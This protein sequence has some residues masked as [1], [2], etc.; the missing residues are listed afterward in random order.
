MKKKKKGSSLFYKTIAIILPIML[1]TNLIVLSSAYYFTYRHNYNHCAEDVTK[2]AKV[3]EDFVGMY[4]LTKEDDVKQCNESISA[5]CREFEITYAYVL[6]IDPKTKNETYITLGAGKDA[7]ETYLKERYPGYTVEGCVNQEQI[8]VVSGKKDYAVLR[9]IS[10]IDDTVTC[11]V[12]LKHVYDPSLNTFVETEKSTGCIVGAEVSFQEII[13]DSRNNFL[14]ILLAS[15]VLSTLM[16]IVFATVAKKKIADPATAISRYMKNFVAGEAG[17]LEKIQDIKGV[18]EYTDMAESFNT[19]VDEINHY[20][21]D[22]ENLNKEKHIAE[23]EMNITRSIQLGLLPPAEFNNKDVNI[24]A[25]TLPAREVGGDLYAY[26]VIPNGIFFAVADVSGKG[27]SAALFVS[28]AL[29]LLHMYAALGYTPT[30]AMAAYNNTLAQN[31]PGKHFITTFAAIYNPADRSLSYTNAGHNV[32]YLLKKDGLVPL[33]G[34]A[35]MAAGVFSGV[36]YESRTVTLDE[37][38]VIFLYTDGVNEAQNAKG[39]FFT[40]ERLEEILKAH[41]GENRHHIIKDVLAEVNTFCADAEQSDDIT[42]FTLKTAGAFYHKDLHLEANVQNLQILN[43]TIESLPNVEM[44]LKLDLNLMA[45]E[46]FVNLCS[47]AYEGKEG[48]IDIAIN[49]AEKAEIIFS[50]SGTQYNPTR[51]ILD[52]EQYDHEHT[53]GGLGKFITFQIADDYEYTYEGGKNILKLIKNID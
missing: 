50:D 35:G 20:I 45:E 7:A 19:M 33:D 31:N 51:N 8:D 49:I 52:I 4:D 16:V 24:E 12:P 48:E 53:V 40:T 41:A 13:R 26:Q 29:T 9:D 44:Q 27:V 47:Y 21:G 22:I 37:G 25:Y 18:A 10:L 36:E 2:A 34:A 38:D 11:Y 3:I 23:A 14:R 28:R 5:L 30:Q 32:P 6:R 1:V 15:V 46:I 39:E 17:S 43:E 42:M